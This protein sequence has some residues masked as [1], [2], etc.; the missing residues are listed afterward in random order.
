MYIYSPARGVIFPFEIFAR[1]SSDERP[2]GR[3]R[4]IGCNII[5][6]ARATILHDN[7]RSAEERKSQFRYLRYIAAA[8][9]TDG[10]FR[11]PLS[12]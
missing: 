3:A 7:I 11:S 10:D 2:L 12:A 1:I 8:A 5:R 4:V 9:T 6:S